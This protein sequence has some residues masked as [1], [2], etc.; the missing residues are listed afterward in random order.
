MAVPETVLGFVGVGSGLWV[1]AWLD[2]VRARDGGG[3]RITNMRSWS[4]TDAFANPAAP[5]GGNANSPDSYQG[6]IHLFA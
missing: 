2:G 6:P 4:Q 5:T 1:R 3:G